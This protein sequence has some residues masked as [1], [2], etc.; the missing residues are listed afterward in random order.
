MSEI[1]QFQIRGSKGD[2]YEV[3]AGRKAIGNVWITCTCQAGRNG[4]YCKHRFALI[5]GDVGAIEG[6][7]EEQVLLLRDLLQDSDIIARIQDVVEAEA[8]AE[9]AKRKLSAAKSALA[10]A[11]L[12]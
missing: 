7:G 12:D 6:S 4:L 8:A 11:M 3:K 5:D 2:I 10:K 1:L 9:A